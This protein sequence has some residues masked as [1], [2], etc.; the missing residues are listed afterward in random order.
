MTQSTKNNA[1]DKARSLIDSIQEKLNQLYVVAPTLEGNN[2]IHQSLFSS[3]TDLTQAAI[4]LAHPALR[5][6][7][8][9][10]TSA[11]KSTLVNALMGRQIA[12][13]DA[14]ELSAGILHLVHSDQRHLHIKP[15]ENLWNEVNESY[16]ND[17][18]VY[19]HVREE[20]FKK[21]HEAKKDRTVTVPEIRIEGPLLPAVWTDLLKLPTGVGIEIYDLPGLNSIADKGNLKVIQDYLKQCFSLVV[22]NYSHTDTSNRAELLKEVKNVVAALGGKTDAMLFVLNG[23]NLRNEKDD[24]LLQR[25]SEFAIAIQT[26]LGLSTPPNIIPINALALFYTQ[27]AWGWS[28]P[29]EQEPTTNAVIQTSLIKEFHKDCAKFIKEYQKG[30]N[31]IKNWFRDIED[32]LENNNQYLPDELLTTEKLKE[33]VEWTWKNSGGN[34]L[35]GELRKRVQESF[36]EIVI[37]PALIQPLASLDTLLSTLDEYNKT[38]RLSDTTAVEKKKEELQQKFTDLQSFLEQESLDFEEEIKQ[39]IQSI[40]DA[41]TGGKKTDIDIAIDSLFGS[42]PKDPEAAETLRTIVLDIKNDLTNNVIIPVRDFYGEDYVSIDELKEDL[43]KSLSPELRD[44]IAHAADRHRYVTGEF[45]LNQVHKGD[46]EQ[47]RKLKNKEITTH[48]LFKE[49]RAGLTAR[50]SYILQTRDHAMQQALSVL[51]VR[52]IVDIEQRIQTELPDNAETL[53]AIYRQK[54]VHV[55][56]NSLPDNIFSL[57]EV[58]SEEFSKKDKTG[59]SGSCFKSA[60]YEDIDYIKLE[61]PNVN[62]MA[63]IW[64]EGVNQAES[65][66]WKAVG[67][68]FAQ[69]ASVQNRLFQE[70]LREAQTHLFELLNQRLEQSEIEY[71]EKLAELDALN[72]LCSDLKTDQDDLKMSGNITQSNNEQI[73]MG[74]RLL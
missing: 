7:T 55:E 32:E 5:I 30:N 69:S 51:Q 3:Y 29:T 38:Q 26:E 49:M 63:D 11:G 64:I 52:G 48:S 65:L 1:L 4:K 53:L 50:A 42:G 61:L 35:W 62:E 56:F 24:P 72:Q 71:Q 23:V 68:W 28:N 17:S 10:T 16:T 41:M 6:A 73:K 43:N 67:E 70:S 46:I 45:P 31:D 2:I 25:L 34:V 19:E 47:E 59:E 66:L 13:M 20:I 39:N 21:Y 12:P 15:I 58:K 22:M 57:K 40:S 27:C 14:A 60:T 18:N 54:L 9:G 8:I 44:S 33:W 36:A 74:L 37:A